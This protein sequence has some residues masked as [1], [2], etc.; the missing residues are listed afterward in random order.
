MQMPLA[1]WLQPEGNGVGAAVDAATGA[2]DVK[3]VATSNDARRKQQ[4][5]NSI[6]CHRRRQPQTSKHCSFKWKRAEAIQ[7]NLAK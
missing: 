1:R 3:T 7:L 4:T 5:C 6:D 2:I